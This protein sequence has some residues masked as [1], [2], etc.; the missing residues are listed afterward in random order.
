[1]SDKLNPT[2]Q[3]VK[4]RK[5]DDLIFR[6]ASE[7]LGFPKVFG[8]QV[9]TISFC[10]MQVAPPERVLHSCHAHLAPG[11]SQHPI[12][13]DVETLREGHNFSAL[14]VLRHSTLKMDC[15]VTASFQIAPEREVST[16]N[17]SHATVPGPEQCSGRT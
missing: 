12:I 13:Y 17:R 8:G 1:M 9:V 7:D 11:D 14:R 10:C 3:I 6:G 4:I 2:H 16:I 15:H 5:I